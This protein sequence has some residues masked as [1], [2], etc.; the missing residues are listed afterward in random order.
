MSKL[1]ANPGDLFKKAIIKEILSWKIPNLNVYTEVFVGSRFIGQKR[2]LDIV[3]EYNNKTLGIE[4]KTQQS[5]GTAYQKLPYAIEDAKRCPIPTIIVFSGKE[6]KDD[7]RALLI[8]SGI[9]L[10]IE[11]DPDHGFGFGLD[12][13]KQRIKIELGLNWLEDQKECRVDPSQFE[14]F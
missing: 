10:E 13:L 2:K 4:A 7:I 8:S 3:V 1:K 5:G 6:M 14:L 11:W 9:G 12:I